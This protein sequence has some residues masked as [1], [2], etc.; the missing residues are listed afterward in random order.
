MFVADMQPFLTLPAHATATALPV[1]TFFAAFA[2]YASRK[3]QKNYHCT[4]F[5]PFSILLSLNGNASPL[6]LKTHSR[7]NTVLP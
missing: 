6:P 1:V 3:I 4:L 7:S 2:R 5:P